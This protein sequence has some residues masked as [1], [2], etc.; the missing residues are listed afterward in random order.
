MPLKMT[1]PAQACFA[2]VN[3]AIDPSM[4]VMAG[5]PVLMPLMTQAVGLPSST[6]A[7]AMLLSEFV[8]QSPQGCLAVCHQA[9][10]T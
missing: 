10:P 5:R 4:L 3:A 7:S 6:H 9:V 2:V 8:K 1:G